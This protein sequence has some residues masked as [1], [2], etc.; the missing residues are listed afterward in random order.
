[1]SPRTILSVVAVAAVSGLGA[2]QAGRAADTYAVDGVHSSVVF[3]VKHMN[4]SNA[5]GRFNNIAGT[6]TLDEANPAESKLDFQVKSDSID[7]AD[8]KRDQHLKSPD[9]FNAVQYPAITFKSQS[10]TKAGGAY[11]V[12]GDLTLHGVTKPV[13]IKVVPTG[14]GKDM[15]GTPIAG[16]ETSF[17][18]KR[19]DYG[20][21]KMV[22]PV[23]DDVWVNV[24]VEATRK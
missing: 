10:V 15:R 8:A 20:M 18:I 17:N 21:S 22:G 14:S 12:T 19:S 5:W 24:S 2:G 3:R 9:F 6:F 1:M 23:G 4:T 11:E 13:T 7:T 16:I